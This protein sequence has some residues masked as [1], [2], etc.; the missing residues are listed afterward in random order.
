MLQTSEDVFNNNQH[1]V[2]EK[3]HTI[4]RKS[5]SL[6]T[7][8]VGLSEIIFIIKPLLECEMRILDE[9]MNDAFTQYKNS[10]AKLEAHYAEC[11]KKHPTD[12]DHEFSEYLRMERDRFGSIYDKYY[13][14]HSRELSRKKGKLE[15]YDCE[16]QQEFER[17]W[18]DWNHNISMHVDRY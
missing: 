1:P 13:D 5:M 14:K 16:R 7:D 18:D 4:Y 17:E 9:K 11:Y 12:A 2:D 10:K 15:E 8:R 6:L 3:Q